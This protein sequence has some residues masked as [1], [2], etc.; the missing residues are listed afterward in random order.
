MF[1]VDK[2]VVFVSYII[3]FSFIAT[4]IVAGFEMQ[5]I[6]VF[7]SSLALILTFIPSLIGKNYQIGLPIEFELFLLV[8]IFASIM[9]GEIHSYYTRF[10]WWDVVLHISSGLI[11]G[12]IGFLIIFILNYEKKIH[13]N[14]NPIFIALFSFS[15]ALSIGVIWEIF[16]FSMDQ[17]FGFNMQ[18]SGIVDTMWDLIVDSIGALIVVTGGY[19]YTKKVKVP[20]FHHMMFKFR[21]KNPRVFLKT[22]IIK[23]KKV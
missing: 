14:L 11:L 7:L 23:K 17:I 20:I 6:T 9:L 12:M 3:R 13:L 21:E 15:F 16:E 4:I 1:R 22:K 2:F 10:W 19:F 18:K 5:W 8:F